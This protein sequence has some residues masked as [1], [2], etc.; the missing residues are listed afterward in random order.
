MRY[1]MYL[2]LDHDDPSG[3]QHRSIFRRVGLGIDTRRPLYAFTFQTRAHTQGTYTINII[4]IL[5][6]KR[7]VLS[8][9]LDFD[10]TTDLP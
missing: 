5:L 8:G 9:N 3:H 10:I 2:D 7:I 6:H 1:N 4:N